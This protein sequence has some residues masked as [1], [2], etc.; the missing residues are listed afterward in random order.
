MDLFNF[1]RPYSEIDE[2]VFEGRN[3]AYG[4]YDLRKHSGSYLGKAFVVSGFLFGILSASVI[5][6]NQFQTNTP[7]VVISQKVKADLKPIE[8]QVYKQPE[9]KPQPAATPPPQY[10][11]YNNQLPSP[12]KEPTTEVER[13]TPPKDAV[14][15]IKTQDGVVAPPHYVEITAPPQLTNVGSGNGDAQQSVSNDPFTEVDVK[16]DFQG[17]LEAFRTK[18][19]NVF[20]TSI[21][22]EDEGRVTAIVSFIVEKDG[23]ISNVKA[24][25]KNKTF[26]REAERTVKSVRG[27]WIPAKVKGQAVR[28]YFKIPITMEFEY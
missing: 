16:A 22:S 14:A 4:A 17:G 2:L 23:S 19:G 25:G 24:E 9:T 6:L 20:D 8:D 15:G 1:F 5:L 26:N 21:M 13:I 12:T 11:T 18:V 28:S 3:K 27:K 7:P 10:K